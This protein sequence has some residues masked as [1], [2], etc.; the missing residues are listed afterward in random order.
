M[1]NRYGGSKIS[2]CDPHVENLINAIVLLCIFSIKLFVLFSLLE[3]NSVLFITIIMIS[4]G[5][6]CISLTREIPPNQNTSI[7]SVLRTGRKKAIE[8]PLPF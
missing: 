8:A 5:S 7:D 4:L 6:I 2:L 1:L 3:K